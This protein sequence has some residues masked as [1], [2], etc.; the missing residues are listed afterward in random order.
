MLKPSDLIEGHYYWIHY[1]GGKVVEPA[2]FDNSM[3]YLIGGDC[4]IGDWDPDWNTVY[5]LAEIIPP[6]AE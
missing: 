4:L 1:R 6:E 2:M 5:V 3:W